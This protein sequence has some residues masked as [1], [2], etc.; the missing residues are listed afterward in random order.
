MSKKRF[1]QEEQKQKRLTNVVEIIR[2][3]PAGQPLPWH[4]LIRLSVAW[5]NLGYSASVRYLQ[6]VE[7]I[8]HL[9]QGPILECG[10]GATT[11]LIGL[12]AERNKRQVWTLEHHADWSAHMQRM[13]AHFNLDHLTVCHA[14]LKCYGEYEWYTLP[15]EFEENT[16]GMVVCDGPPGDIRGGRYGLIP[17]M[18]TALRNDCRILLDDTHRKKEQVLIQRWAAER[19]IWFSE[20]GALGTCTEISFA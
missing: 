6:Q 10:S 2:Q 8:F 17:V 14:P 15:A 4:T 20:L 3:A 1:N 16:F 7:R 18:N 13:M 11:L 9:S 5:G 12:L 19:R